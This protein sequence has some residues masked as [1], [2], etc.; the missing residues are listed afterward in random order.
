MKKSVRNSFSLVVKCVY[1]DIRGLYKTRMSRDVSILRETSE[2]DA[3]GVGEPSK[4]D[5]LVIV[6]I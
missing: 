6:A 5:K 2:T 4:P 1:H 3:L